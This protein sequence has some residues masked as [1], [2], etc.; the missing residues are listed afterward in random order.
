[1]NEKELEN[2]VKNVT[3]FGTTPSDVELT[4]EQKKLSTISMAVQATIVQFIN[5]GLIPIDQQLHFM[6]HLQDFANR[7]YNGESIK[8]PN[9]QQTLQINSKAG[10]LFHAVTENALVN[11]SANFSE[12]KRV[13]QEYAQL[14][15]QGQ[16]E[17]SGKRT[18]N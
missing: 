17:Q 15:E 18:L 12:L 9:T 1:M 4:P 10:T 16:T 5:E 14:Q 7:I 11:G 6:G 3:D 13:S 8:L 2:F